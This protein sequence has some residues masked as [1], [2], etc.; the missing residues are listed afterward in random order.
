MSDK[1]SLSNVFSDGDVHNGCERYKLCFKANGWNE[2]AQLP[3][4]PTLLAGRAFSVYERLELTEYQR[5]SFGEMKKEFLKIMEP[6][7]EER[8]RFARRSLEHRRLLPGDGLDT[9]VYRLERLLD[10]SCPGLSPD[11]L[12]RERLDRLID[13]PPPLIWERLALMP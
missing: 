13:G 11:I 5:K 2:S 8:R 1:L 4:L 9:I 3:R 6:D 7:T 10:R 12:R